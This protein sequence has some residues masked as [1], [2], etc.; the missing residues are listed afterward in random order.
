MAISSNWNVSIEHGPTSADVHH[1]VVDATTSK[2]AKIKAEQWA[3]DNN[4]V[5]P[6]YSEPYKDTYDTIEWT[7]EEEEEFFHIAKMNIDY[8]SDG[9]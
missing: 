1:I 5:N 7:Q 6:M 2:A 3:K 4:I 8:N 9:R